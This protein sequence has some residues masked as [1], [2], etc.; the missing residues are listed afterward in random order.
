MGWRQIC[1]NCKDFYVPAL[2]HPHSG[3]APKMLL[4]LLRASQTQDGD[5]HAL[6]AELR[7]SP[8]SSLAYL[9]GRTEPSMGSSG[10]HE[11]QKCSRQQHQNK[12]WRKQRCPMGHWEGW[13]LPGT[14]E[15]K[16]NPPCLNRMRPNR[17]SLCHEHLGQCFLTWRETKN[18]QLFL[19]KRLQFPE[20]FKPIPQI[21]A[22]L[23]LLWRA[24]QTSA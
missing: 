13:L 16:H 17:H 24:R 15:T 22:T 5:K 12:G 1:L 4:G 11:L 9:K 6:P 14:G 20:K 21:P 8:G 7:R 23:V 19:V 10:A 3:P 2:L 18:F